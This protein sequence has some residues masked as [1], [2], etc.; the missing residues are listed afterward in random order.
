[1]NLADLTSVLVVLTSFICAA[2]ASA[3]SGAPWWVTA[4]FGI[5]GLLIGLLLAGL[6][7]R[8][9]YALLNVK[10]GFGFIG[11]TLF[12]VVMLIGAGVLVAAGSLWILPD[13]DDAPPKLGDVSES[14][15]YGEPIETFAVDSS[16]RTH[17]ITLTSST[18]QTRPSQNTTRAEQDDAVQPATAV[19]SKSEGKENAKPE[20]EGRSQ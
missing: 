6:S 19:D 12:P 15:Y 14:P 4:L 8:I 1:M 3:T 20:S 16:G 7:N 17:K 5:A 9:S 11:Y 13:G 18:L 10:N 2:M